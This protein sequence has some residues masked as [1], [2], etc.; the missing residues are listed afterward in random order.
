MASTP[1]NILLILSDD[2]RWD[3]IHVLSGLQAQTPVLDT[4]ASE[5][6]VFTQARHQGSFNSAVCVPSRAMIHSGQNFLRS[7][8]TLAGRVTLGEMLKARGYHS[9]GTG[10]WHNGDAAIIRSF[11]TAANITGGFL[12]SGHTVGFTTKFLNNGSITSGNNVPPTHST[13]LVANSAISFL[14]AHSSDTPFFMYVGFNAP[15]DPFN[16]PEIYR[17]P[18][19]DINGQSTLPLP[20]NFA[21]APAFDHG[22]L[23]IRDELLLSR[24]LQEQAVKNQNANYQAM[25]DHIDKRVGDILNALEARG[26]S[27]NTLVIFTSDHGLGRGSHGLLGK[28]NLYEHSLRVPLIMRGPGVPAGGQNH[29]PV[30]L[31]DLFATLADYADA[32]LPAGQVDGLSL[33][34]LVEGMLPAH[35]SVTYHGYAELMRAVNDGRWKLIEYRVSGVRTTQLFDLHD[36]PHEMHNLAGLPEHAA[37]LARLRTLLIEQKNLHGDNRAY[38]TNHDLLPPTLSAPISWI[39][40]QPTTGASDLIDGFP[41][42]ARN[43]GAYSTTV[44]GT[45]FSSVNLGVGFLDPV[46][47]GTMVSTGDTGFDNL[48]RTFTYGGGTT[49]T[50][51]PITGLVSGQTYRVQL[52]YNDQRTESADRVMVV[53]DGLGNTAQLPS[54]ATPGPQL[55]D[56]GMFVI[57]SFTAI[58]ATQSITFQPSGFGNSHVNAVFVCADESFALHDTDGDGQPDAVELKAG[59]DPFDPESHFRWVLPTAGD[60]EWRVSW[61]G[62]PTGMYAPWTSPD[63]DAWSKQGNSQPGSGRIMTFTLPATNRVYVGM[64][65]E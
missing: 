46:Y 1:P 42:F 19:V 54:G 48:V 64:G 34:P 63:L 60:S 30:F 4:L 65:F 11:T 55:D 16:T 61:F 39:M 50:T 38:W 8:D 40:A 18:Y 2:Q 7:S 13:D 44:S 17:E 27:S 37:T 35:R 26:F 20:L 47:S 14:N 24:P 3:S 53:G 15:H 49:E 10:K 59:T 23:S 28:Q 36:D 52:F 56:Y 22:V 9:F 41:V 43:G 33:R 51:I 58:G 31:H 45:V 12:S 5:G 57:G 62:S 6:F 21:S 25:V 29:S 32:P